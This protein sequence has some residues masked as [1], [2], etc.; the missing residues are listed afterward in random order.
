MTINSTLFSYQ[1][2]S[3]FDDPSIY[4]S[5]ISL[6]STKVVWLGNTIMIYKGSYSIFNITNLTMVLS[7][8]NDYSSLF[9]IYCCIL[10]ILNTNIRFVLVFFIHNTYFLEIFCYII[11]LT[12]WEGQSILKIQIL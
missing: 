6:I 11:L 4:S 12:R 3:S 9:E 7:Q 2:I 10:T 1:L 8:N 5:I